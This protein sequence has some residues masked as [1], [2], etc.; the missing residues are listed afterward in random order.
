MARGRDVVKLGDVTMKE[1][2]MTTKKI[3]NKKEKDGST[4]QKKDGPRRALQQKR[5]RTSTN[6]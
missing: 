2:K 4:K 3:N 1:E 5:W 6:D